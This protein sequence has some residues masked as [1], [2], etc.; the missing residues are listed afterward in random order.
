MGGKKNS[1]ADGTPSYDIAIY[2]AASAHTPL[3][4]ATII[5]R[6]DAATAYHGRAAAFRLIAEGAMTGRRFAK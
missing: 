2:T 6:P 4:P 5:A 1:L 3:M